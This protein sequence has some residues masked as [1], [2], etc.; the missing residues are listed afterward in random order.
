MLACNS[1]VI[2]KPLQ[3]SLSQDDSTS[4]TPKRPR[5]QSDDWLKSFEIP[6]EF[7]VKTMDAIKSKDGVVTSKCRNEIVQTLAML[8]WDCNH[9]PSSNAY[10]TICERLIGAFPKLADDVGDD[11]PQY[12]SSQPYITCAH[13]FVIIIFRDLGK[14]SYETGGNSFVAHLPLKQLLLK[15]QR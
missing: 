7:S 2:T 15:E 13:N 12:V 8:I 9:Y 10:N 4:W 1:V 14:L 6:S 11:E 5:C 3:L